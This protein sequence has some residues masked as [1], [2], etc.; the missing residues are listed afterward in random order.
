M[1]LPS[2]P[3]AENEATAMHGGRAAPKRLQ[4]GR[5]E[6]PHCMR[7]G[8]AGEDHLSFDCLARKLLQL[9]AELGYDLS[10]A[11]LEAADAARALWL[12]LNLSWSR[13]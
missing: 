7:L 1:A 2:A 12:D 8:C 5:F 4:D 3:C 11:R 13:S 9:E 6:C 10:C